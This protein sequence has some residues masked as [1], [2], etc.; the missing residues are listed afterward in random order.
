MNQSTRYWIAKWTSDP[1]SSDAR[2]R[3]SQQIAER[4]METMEAEKELPP[5]IEIALH[6]NPRARER[7]E[8]ISQSHRR[9]HL[10]GIFYYRTPESR[11]RR[12]NKCVNELLGK[13]GS[14]ETDG[15]EF[16]RN[17]FE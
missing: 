1:K 9:S 5:M 11:T 4:L 17:E 8:Q 13:K 16:E 10:M 3:R 7:W 14:K 6:Q 15:A 12:L 2:T